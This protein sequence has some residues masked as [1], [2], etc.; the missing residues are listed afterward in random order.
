MNFKKFIKTFD[1]K[2][3]KT[4]LADP[5]WRFMS[6]SSIGSPDNTRAFR[7]NTLP[8]QEICNMPVQQ[9][10][11]ENTHL[12]LWVPNALLEEGLK[13]MKEWGFKYKTNIVWQA[14]T[15]VGMLGEIKPKTTRLPGT[16]TNIIAKHSI[17]KYCRNNHM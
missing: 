10:A 7:Y 17:Q 1:D 5:P 6:R 12:Y 4:I 16:R 15:P 3:F 14:L 11:A 8:L 13:V 2:R 9:I